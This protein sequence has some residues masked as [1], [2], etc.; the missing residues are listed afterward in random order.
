MTIGEE[1]FY[2]MKIQIEKVRLMD[3]RSRATPCVESL[4]HI[5]KGK[6]STLSV[7]LKEKCLRKVTTLGKKKR[8]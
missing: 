7:S 6:K 2:N 5:W 1:E 3:E 8:N 4:C